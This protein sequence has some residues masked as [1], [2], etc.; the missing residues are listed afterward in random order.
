MTRTSLLPEDARLMSLQKKHVCIH[1]VPSTFCTLIM[2][3][4]FF[5]NKLFGNKSSLS[6]RW[7][8]SH[9]VDGYCQDVQVEQGMQVAVAAAPAVNEAVDRLLNRSWEQPVNPPLSSHCF[10][11][12]LFRDS[13]YCRVVEHDPLAHPKKHFTVLIYCTLLVVFL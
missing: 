1:L 6:Y 4:G 12:F 8:N 13:C 5:V 10:I 7:R 11:L 9:F 3:D 2:R